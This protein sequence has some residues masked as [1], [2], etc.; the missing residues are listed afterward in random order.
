[1]AVQKLD[2]KTVKE[3]PSSRSF[4]VGLLHDTSKRHINDRQFA[5]AF[6]I[7]LL[8]VAHETGSPMNAVFS[9]AQ[10]EG[11]ELHRLAKDLVNSYERLQQLQIASSAP[12]SRSSSLSR[13]SDEEREGLCIRTDD[14]GAHSADIRKIREM[15]LEEVRNFRSILLQL[16]RLSHEVEIK[17]EDARDDFAKSLARM[18]RFGIM[19]SGCLEKLMLGT[20]DLEAEMMPMAADTLVRKGLSNALPASICYD[21]PETENMLVMANPIFSTLI[22]TNLYSNAKRAM[23]QKGVEHDIIITA[24]RQDGRLLVECTDVGC[25]MPKEIMDK[26]NSGVAV[27][28]K[29]EEGHGIGFQYCRE[30]A[31]KM[32]GRLYVKESAEGIG[33]TVALELRHAPSTSVKQFTRLCK[34]FYTAMAHEVGNSISALR[35]KASVIG[36]DRLFSIADSLQMIHHRTRGLISLAAGEAPSSRFNFFSD[37]EK[38]RLKIKMGAHKVSADIRAI[39]AIGLQ[40]TRQFKE[41]L[42]KLSQT[43]VPDDVQQN[44]ERLL[45]LG[46]RIA[47]CLEK[48]MLGSLDLDSEV[49]ELRLSYVLSQGDKG[50]CKVRMQETDGIGATKVLVNPLFSALIITNIFSNAVRAADESGSPAMEVTVHKECDRVVIEYTDSGCGMTAEMVEKLNTGIA[51]TTK[52][53]ESGDHGIGFQYSRQL[54][55]KMDGRLYVKETREGIGTTIALELKVVPE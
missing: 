49:M 41:E 8:A 20:L 34:L 15:G 22:L 24:Y 25:G 16:E 21:R 53:D 23:K 18:N 52:N 40:D 42:I 48:L 27:T 28:T 14:S 38:A 39:M 7:F 31:E 19:L 37:N 33:T 2:K 5:E 1:M 36:D 13:F 9:I 4:S 47:N 29:E 6:R 55:E 12:F 51:F 46:P 50:A 43:H 10:K 30:L 54:A 44:Q 32:G 45:R 26:L 11:N 35:G 17:R 3:K